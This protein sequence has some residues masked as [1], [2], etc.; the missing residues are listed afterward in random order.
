MLTPLLKTKIQIPPVHSAQ[1]ARQHLIERLNRGLTGKLGVNSRTG[2]VAK[3]R[4]AGLIKS[5]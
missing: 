4:A 1:V 5:V 2:A 3:A